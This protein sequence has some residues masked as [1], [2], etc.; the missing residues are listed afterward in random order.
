MRSSE[1]PTQKMFLSLF[2]KLVQKTKRRVLFQD[3]GLILQLLWGE[4]EE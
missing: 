4:I 1:I 3:Q 2:N